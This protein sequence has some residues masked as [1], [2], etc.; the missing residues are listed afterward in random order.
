MLTEIVV[1]IITLTGTIGAAYITVKYKRSEWENKREPPVYDWESNKRALVENPA[2]DLIALH[3]EIDYRKHPE[4]QVR[5]I[6][7][8]NES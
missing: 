5:I 4:T 6:G 3:A 7:G 8:M 2:D 1:A